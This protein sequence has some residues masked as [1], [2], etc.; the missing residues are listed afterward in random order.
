MSDDAP[1]YLDHHSTT[2]IDPRVREAMEPWLGPDFGNAASHA[3]VFGWRAEAAVE[4]ARARIASALGAREPREIIF[5]SGATESNNLALKGVARAGRAT[6]DHLVSVATEHRAVLDP[7]AALAREGFSTTVLPVDPGGRVAPEM[8]AAALCDRSALVSVMAANNEIGVLQPMA[9][10]AQICRER[11]VPL[12]SDAAQ[13]VGRTAFDVGALGLDLASLCAHKL[14]GPKGVGALY[15]RRRRPRLRIEP[16]LHGGGH[17]YG[18]RSG[19]LPVALIVGF[20][21]AVELAVAEREGEGARLAAL[22][23]RLLA[24]LAADPGGVTRNGDPE[25]ALPHNLSVAFDG[26]DAVQLLAALPGVALST[27]SACSSAAPGP[28]H[29]LVALGLDRDRIAGTVRVGLG[30]DNTEAEVDRAAGLIAA[31]VTRLR[32]AQPAASKLPEQ[33]R[34]G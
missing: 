6:H 28:S 17:E 30:R 23:D 10:I 4:D 25:H 16:L 11:S 29:V 15:V 7:L 19:T 8:V 20:A 26:I 32:G 18:L 12:H 13:A 2:P 24:R 1:I 14:G 31:A 34:R 27:G 22:R 33:G 9:E 5:T 3:H 21:K